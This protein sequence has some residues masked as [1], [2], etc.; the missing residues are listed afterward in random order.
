ML[1]TKI[2][3]QEH[4]SDSNKGTQEALIKYETSS[5]RSDTNSTILLF[6]LILLLLSI[7]VNMYLIVLV[8]KMVKTRIDH[9]ILLASM[10]V[11]FLHL[12]LYFATC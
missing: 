6:F 5:P 2:E 9:Y 1:K 7:I 10:S 11:H 4:R 8:V 3:Q 12:I